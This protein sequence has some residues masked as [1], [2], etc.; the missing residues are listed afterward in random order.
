MVFYV[1][2]VTFGGILVVQNYQNVRKFM[3][4]NGG[5]ANV[6]REVVQSNDVERDISSLDGDNSAEIIQTL[7]TDIQVLK[8]ESERLKLRWMELE[9][10][11]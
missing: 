6:L 8:H 1:V 2:D 11:I 3:K 10:Q 7:D 5:Y 4:M 9:K